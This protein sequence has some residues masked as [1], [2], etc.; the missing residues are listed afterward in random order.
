MSKFAKGKYA[1]AISDRSGQAFPWREMV[2]EWNG[3]FVHVSEYEPKQPQLEPKPFVADPQGLEQ[4]RPQRFPSDQIGGGN[5][6]ANLTLP[7]DFAFSDLSNNSMVPEDPGQINSR[8]EVSIALGEVSA[9]VPAVA[10]QTYAVTVA[11]GTLY[12]ENEQVTYTGTSSTTFTGCTRGANSTTAAAHS[13]D[14]QV[15]QFTGGGVPT[16]IVR[17]LDNNYILYPFP[18]KAYSLKFDYFTFPSDLSVHGS[19]TTIPDRFAPTIVDG[20]TAYAYQYRGELEQYQL[21]FARFEQGIKN[22][23]TLLVNKY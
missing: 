4:A 6:V 13:D 14:V 21:N 9:G 16:H 8:R 11:S 7:G 3:A 1:L 19:T 2:T 22:M 10:T 18:D 5:M 20:A 17:T 15:A 12:I 23:Q